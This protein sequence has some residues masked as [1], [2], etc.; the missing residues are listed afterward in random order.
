[1]MLENIR[2]MASVCDALAKRPVAHLVYVS[3]DA[4]DADGP[5]PLTETSPAAPTSC[6]RHAPRAQAN[7]ARHLGRDAAR[8]VAANARLRR[9]RPAQRLRPQHVSPASPTP[10]RRSSCSARARSG[11]IMYDVED[12]AETGGARASIR[13]S[14]GVLNVATGSVASFRAIAEDGGRLRRQAGGRS[15]GGA[16][17]GADAAQRLSPIST[18]RRPSP[19]FP[20]SNTRRSRRRASQPGASDRSFG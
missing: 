12:V 11:A 20:I 18:R 2:M 9:G 14:T 1:M 10:A 16:A 5:L 17:L 15:A 7:A 13:R 3:S 4:V 19:P 8:P 6:R